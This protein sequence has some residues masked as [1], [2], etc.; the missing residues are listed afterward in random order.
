MIL[1]PVDELTPG[2]VV[3]AS[4]LHPAR[5]SLELLAPG[6]VLDAAM[7]RRLAR[8]DVRQLWVHLDG[9]EEL[10]HA[11]AHGLTAAQSQLFH[12]I[13]A[14]L[15][16]RR[17]RVLST[18]SIQNYRGAINDLL[19]EV[20]SS[21]SI[22]GLTNR[23][24][25]RDAPLLAHGAAVAYLC[26]LL[27]LELQAYIAE[28]RSRLE[29]RH[30]RDIGPLGLAGLLHDLAKAE[31]GCPETGATHE[32]ITPD[33]DR[34]PEY[35]EH[36]IRAAEILADNS[37]HAST[38]QAVLLHHQRWDGSGWPSPERL[39]R[40]AERLEGQRL[41]VFARILAAANALDNLMTDA[42]RR[43]RPP[44]EAL[45][46]FASP[47]FDGWF[48]PIVRRGALRQI[49]PF[50]VG[51]RV[52]LTSADE[53]V[54]IAPNR[55]RPCYPAVRVLRG[56]RAGELLDL[57]ERADVRVARAGAADVGAMLYELPVLPQTPQTG[58]ADAA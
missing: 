13:H 19:L 18:A 55:E 9:T 10:D 34:P 45:A 49:P 4:V 28:Q 42:D 57:A 38:R 11:A 2:A 21:R 44:V 8:V 30:A 40:D 7:I 33:P 5:P 6:A 54:V 24:Q 35:D 58:Q 17:D 15:T 37:V 53:A 27:G 51:G 25:A 52:T 50:P 14:D 20:I 29:P 16:R 41:H 46:R 26:L 32:V 36:P 23:V 22:A 3:G 12:T 48:D 1:C 31:D 47:E 39:A 56:E 43:R